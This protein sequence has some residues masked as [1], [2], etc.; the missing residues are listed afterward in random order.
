MRSHEIYNIFNFDFT[1][2]PFIKVL[3]YVGKNREFFTS[4]PNANGISNTKFSR[5]SHDFVDAQIETVESTYHAHY[6]NSDTNLTSINRAR[7]SVRR[8]Q[9]RTLHPNKD[10]RDFITNLFLNWKTFSTSKMII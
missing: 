8:R 4:I 6:F 7:N 9:L 10:E 1:L 2:V 3:V 5:F